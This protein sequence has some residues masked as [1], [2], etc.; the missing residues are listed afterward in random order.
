[1]ELRSVLQAS[2]LIITGDRARLRP[3]VA[4]IIN[5]IAK[6]TALAQG[7]KLRTM[8]KLETRYSQYLNALIFAGEIRDYR[9][10]PFRLRLAPKCTYCPDFFVVTKDGFEVH[11][12]KGWMRE[13]ALVKL[14][15]AAAA[16]P[17]WTF[18]LVKRIKGQWQIHSI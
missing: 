3:S 14:K 11:E 16:F 1:M 9:Y 10:E 6:A 12:C 18:K 13:D 15:V 5:T 7:I 17:W 4:Q 2:D 8:N